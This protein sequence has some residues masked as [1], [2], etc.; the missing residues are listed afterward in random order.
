[1][2]NLIQNNFIIAFILL[3]DK[4]FNDFSNQLKK[5]WDID[6]NIVSYNNKNTFT[7]DDI[8]FEYELASVLLSMLINFQRKIYGIIILIIP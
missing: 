8:N 3:D 1:M 7:I 4:N 6:I 5:D 2:N